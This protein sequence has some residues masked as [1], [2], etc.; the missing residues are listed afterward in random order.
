MAR[1]T[2]PAS[3]DTVATDGGYRMGVGMPAAQALV[4]AEQRA[5]RQRTRTLLAK[6]DALVGESEDEPVAAGDRRAAT[7]CGATTRAA[8]TWMRS[9]AMP[10]YGLDPQELATVYLRPHQD[11]QHD[12]GA[13]V[14]PS[15]RI[16]R[17]R[18][19]GSVDTETAREVVKRNMP[20][21][22]RD[23]IGL[24]RDMAR[25]HERESR[26]LR[27]AE[28]AEQRD[29]REAE[30]ASVECVNGMTKD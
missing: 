11:E 25:D 4:R 2:K 28:L 23:T 29:R 7:R 6:L 30:L 27:S 1:T 21:S 13:G 19:G 10:E 9:Q 24:G 8:S 5:L 20:V 22:S 15:I 26:Y 3:H 17:T 18:G 12:D 14:P 16:W